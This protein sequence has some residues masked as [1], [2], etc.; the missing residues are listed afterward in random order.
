MEEVCSNQSH[1]DDESSFLKD[2]QLESDSIDI[3]E[4]VLD[5]HPAIPDDEM[6]IE[7]ELEKDYREI[8][9]KDVISKF[10]FDY[11]RST[12]LANDVPEIV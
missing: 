5:N 2:S 12:C 8:L 3:V 10:Q 9:E 7:D 6:D 11:N 1:S 4:E